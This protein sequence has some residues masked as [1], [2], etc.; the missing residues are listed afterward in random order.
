MSAGLDALKSEDEQRLPDTIL[1]IRRGARV[2]ELACLE[3]KCARK[4]TKGS[5]PFLSAKN[6][7]QIQPVP[8]ECIL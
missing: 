2:V 1:C 3:N 4:G 8:L 7:V 6:I 5:N